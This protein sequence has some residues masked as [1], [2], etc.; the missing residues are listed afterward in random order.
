MERIKFN[1][2]VN[3]CLEAKRQG[4]DY[5]E[6]RKNLSQEGL[7]EFIIKQ[8]IKETDD[9]FLK[10]IGQKSKSQKGRELLIAAWVLLILGGII[11]L[12]SYLQWVDTK[13]MLIISYG[14][15]LAGLILYI[16]GRAMG[17]KL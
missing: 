15:F 1:Q 16:S 3:T 4:M 17:G 6:I 13:G 2:Y 10:E 14:P 7:D 12:G 11:T 8:I 9:R 5:T